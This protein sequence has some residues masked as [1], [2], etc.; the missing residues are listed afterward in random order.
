[1]MMM[2]KI[3]KLS[4]NLSNQIAAGEVIERP[5][6]VVKE[7][8]ENS[9]DAGSSRIQINFIDAGLKEIQVQ[10][11]GSGISA[12][13][14][15]LA[16]TRHATSK[17]ANEHDLFNVA[18]LGFRG[19]ALASIAAVSHVEI[20][21]STTG[22][23]GVKAV[24]SG[25]RKSSLQKSAAKKGCQITVRDLFF[26]TPARLKYLRTPRTEIMQIVDIVE[27]LCLAYPRVQFILQNKGKTLLQ[28]SGNGNLQQ[29]V[30]N[31]YG[32]HVGEK[33]IAVKTHDSDFEISGLISQP[34]LTRSNRNFISI[35]LNGRYIRNLQ[36]NNAIMAGYGNKLGPRH[37]PIAVLAI[38]V[39]PLLVDVNVHPTKRE[40]RLSKEKELGRLITKMI[41]DALL[42]RNNSEDVFSALN[43][44]AKD[45]LFD[46]LQ[47]RLNKNVTDTTRSTAESTNNKIAEKHTPYVTMNQVREDKKYVLTASWDQNVR[48]QQK[49]PPFP[50]QQHPQE[51]ESA[52]DEALQAHMPLLTVLGQLDN[53]IIAK[54]KG[55]L[56]LIDKSAAKRRINFERIEASLNQDKKPRQMLLTPV[57]LD[58]NHLDF[59]KLKKCTADL[60]K[61]GIQLEEFGNDTFVV[62]SYPT[63]ID[64]DIEESLRK[65]T[66]LYLNASLE[67]SAMVQKIAAAMSR[68]T[69]STARKMG[70]AEMVRLLA[71]L[72]TVSD[73]YRDFEGYTI[74]VRISA[75]D[76]RK[77]FKKEF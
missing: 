70:Q 55:D 4:S 6:S 67:K 41:T 5:A 57:V 65:I 76:L 66:D 1:M 73:P 24:F 64:K 12:D 7:L 13:Q 30:A 58:Y 74:T 15:D 31:I 8:V 22:I 17:I 48:L 54:H 23:S 62:R 40:V 16:F 37:Y 20:I 72:R 14:I 29:D 53:M 3:H 60:A 34:S 50:L 35:L 63:W 46:Q 42:T 56:F 18:T 59:I 75:N 47:F 44:N 11:N 71:D 43:S 32:R 69:V 36:L 68:Q 28:T 45:T 38:K 10:D 21:T 49:L 2:N 19:E 52:A 77:M 26:N 27:R 39:D 25:G 51:A 61:I 9:L 33:M